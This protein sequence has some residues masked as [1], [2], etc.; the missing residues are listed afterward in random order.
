[1]P[2]NYFNLVDRGRIKEGY[3]A[4]LVLLD[5]ESLKPNAT[6]TDPMQLSEGVEWVWV[7]GNAIIEDRKINDKKPG[8]IIRNQYYNSLSK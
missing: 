2:A 5:L 8:K 4:D 1:M 7:N 6:Y 3:F